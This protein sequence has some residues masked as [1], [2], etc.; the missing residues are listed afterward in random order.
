M[1]YDDHQ[2]LQ[3]V[4]EINKKFTEGTC[5]FD[6]PDNELILGEPIDIKRIIKQLPTVEEYKNI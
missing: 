3:V 6:N 1:Q 5:A 4:E 2:N